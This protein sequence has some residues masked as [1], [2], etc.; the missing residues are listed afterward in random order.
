MSSTETDPCRKYREGLLPADWY[1]SGMGC[2]TGHKRS[3]DLKTCT[4]CG[5]VLS[6]A[7]GLHVNSR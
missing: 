2:M 6:Y 1:S 5:K 4:K 7:D 3:E